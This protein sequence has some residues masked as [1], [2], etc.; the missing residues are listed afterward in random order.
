MTTPTNPFLKLYDAVYQLLLAERD[1]ENQLANIVRMR[2][3]ISFGTVN[4]H[5]RNPKDFGVTSADMPELMLWDEGFNWNP[6]ANSTSCK[7][8]QNL[9]LV[10]AT[11]DWR[12]GEFISRL[13]WLTLVNAQRW[14]ESL[15]GLT[16]CGQPFVK[17]FQE[18]A[19]TTGEYHPERQSAPAGWTGIWRMRFDCQLSRINVVYTEPEA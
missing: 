9:S 1:G 14:Q 19:V 18:V 13:H 2:N 12:Y 6:H 11:G 3:R 10:I 5:D 15:G 8:T 16:W 7:W 17:N 4:G